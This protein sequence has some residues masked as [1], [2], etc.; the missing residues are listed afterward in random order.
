MAEN[1]YAERSSEELKKLVDEYYAQ[2][3][4]T[5]HWPA[6]VVARRHLSQVVAVLRERGE[7]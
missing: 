4:N 5:N 2:V 6:R 3:M 1:Q 7:L